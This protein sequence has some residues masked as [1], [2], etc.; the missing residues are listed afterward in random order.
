[1]LRGLLGLLAAMVSVA[2]FAPPAL[3]RPSPYLAGDQILVN[4]YVAIESE[5]LGGL[6]LP[7]GA[8]QFVTV[9][10][11]SLHTLPE[12]GPDGTIFPGAAD[13]SC[14]DAQGREVGPATHCTITV[15]VSP[16]VSNGR[17]EPT[18]NL[19]LINADISSTIAHEVF[20][21]Y[22]AVMAGTLANFNRA[23]DTW[24]VE[25]SAA[26]VESDLVPEDTGARE[27][28][29]IYLKSPGVSLFKRTY[30]AIGFFGH[31]ESSGIS[32]W[33]RFPAMFAATSN[34]AAYNVSV[35]L[36]AA[37]LDSE[38]SSFFRE[39]TFGSAWDQQGANVPTRAEVGFKPTDL[40]LTVSG[41]VALS[42][43]P[44]TD[45]AYEVSLK[46]LSAS[47]PVLEVQ[48][49]KGYVRLRST[50]GG[51]V[52]VVDPNELMLCSDPKGCDCPGQP[53]TDYKQF[54]QGD[55]AITGGPTGGD[56]QLIPHK[57][58]EELLPPRSCEGL[59]PGFTRAPGHAL[60]QA[61]PKSTF[62]ETTK[63]GGY[64]VSECLFLSKGQ[65]A[66]NSE[67]E[68]VLHG[69]LAPGVIVTRDPSVPQATLAFQV[70]RRSALQPSSVAGIGDEA[71]IATLP[72][73]YSHGEV[74]EGATAGVRVRNVDVVFSVAGDPEAAGRQAVLTL[75][76][77]VAAKL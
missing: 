63:P 73:E 56:V 59:L 34:T 66:V 36:S 31:L 14:S 62:E 42:V 68:E 41:A 17:G 76:S 51:A 50:D 1:M 9:R 77:E 23:E 53:P 48:T 4:H 21:C 6:T 72:P 19:A 35:S 70:S 47:T 52:N 38:A 61:V 74:T 60:E 28:W 8:S 67:G 65:V 55:L 25:G 40:K 12:R 29:A 49:P 2:V 27:E 54:E 64:Y 10:E 37:F 26:W 57:R 43:A 11:S 33:T 32:P 39:P 20:H 22:Q 69:A 7:G 13:T 46:K 30:T 16:H 3:A 15:S 18:K 75:L 71:W 24:L 44:Y 58:C 45:G 5:K